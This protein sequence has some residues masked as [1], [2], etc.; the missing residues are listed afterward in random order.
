[1]L[2]SGRMKQDE[3]PVEAARREMQEEVK[4]ELSESSLLEFE[5]TH[6]WGRRYTTF[7]VSGQSHV[8]PEPD[9]REIS[10][11]AFFSISNLPPS[12]SMPTRVRLE[13][14]RERQSMPIHVPAF[15]RLEYVQQR[16]NRSIQA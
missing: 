10:E 2:P 4:C 5:D 8:L 11:A 14:W 3:A 6:F 15:V 9:L 7:I 12:T 1:M 13:R 16:M